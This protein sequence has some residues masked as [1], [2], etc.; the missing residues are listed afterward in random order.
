MPRI[1]RSIVVSA[2]EQG[3]ILRGAKSV[4]EHSASAL[5]ISYGTWDTHSIKRT[6]TFNAQS[7]KVLSVHGVIGTYVIRTL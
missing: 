3:L 6:K 1:I 7:K 2:T 4:D 5:H